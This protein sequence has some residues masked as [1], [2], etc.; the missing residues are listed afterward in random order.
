MIEVETTVEIDRPVAEVFAFVSDQTNAPLWQTDL[1]VVRRVTDGP[2]GVG[3][4]HEFVR[5]FARREMASRN[6]VVEFDPGRYMAF[7][8][9]SGWMT[10]RASYLAE[11]NATG[12]TTLSSQ[13]QFRVRRFGFVLEPILCRVLARDSKRDE[14]R[15]KQLLERRIDA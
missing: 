9:P 2:V 10:G 8:I 4:E 6:R 1:H 11:Q 7:E 5:V 14:A 13:M 12:G 3:S 15:L